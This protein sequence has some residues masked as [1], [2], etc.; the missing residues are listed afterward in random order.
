M[1][2]TATFASSPLLAG[3][4]RAIQ[5]VEAEARAL[6]QQAYGGG[7][8]RGAAAAGQATD[9][10]GRTL[11][12]LTVFL[13]RLKQMKEWL[14]HDERLLPIVDEYIGQRV[15]AMEKRTNAV[16]VRLAVIT[17]VAGALLGWLTALAQNPATIVHSLFH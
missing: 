1:A 16:N 9:G 6:Q 7:A 17:T 13:S 5:E 4:D 14:E 15:K 10:Q 2:T 12:D 8:Q 11:E 3:I